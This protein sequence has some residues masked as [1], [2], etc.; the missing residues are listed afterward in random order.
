MKH[1][2]TP[3]QAAVKASLKQYGI[4]H[5]AVKKDLTITAYRNV[6]IPTEAIV[7]GRLPFKFSTVKGH[8]VVEPG[9][10]RTLEGCPT[11]VV[12]CFNF[13]SNPMR[14]SE[15]DIRCR[16]QVGDVVCIQ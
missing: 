13:A 7:E 9:T 16:C 15:D 4:T 11:R 14:V 1:Q 8:F 6:R 12:G 10:L 2:L 5:C 3:A